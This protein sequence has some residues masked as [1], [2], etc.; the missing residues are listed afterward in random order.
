[1][2]KAIQNQPL[3]NKGTGTVALAI[4]FDSGAADVACVWFTACG[5]DG[6]SVDLPQLE[7]NF[8]SSLSLVPHCVQ[9]IAANPRS[10]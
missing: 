9:N 6:A 2:T 3:R 10:M 1:M 5:A 7:Q 4:G 8:A